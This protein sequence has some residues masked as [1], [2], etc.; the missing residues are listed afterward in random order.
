MIIQKTIADESLPLL[1]NARF[2]RE[3]H[4]SGVQHRLVSQDVILGLTITEGALPEEHLEVDDTD[5][6]YV[7]FVAGITQGERSMKRMKRYLCC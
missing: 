4:L 6:P 2:G 5:G 3:V 7:N 1:C